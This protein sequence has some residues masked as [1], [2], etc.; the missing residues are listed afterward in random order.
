MG[1]TK[2]KP[3]KKRP[4]FETTSGIIHKKETPASIC[5]NIAGKGTS[6]QQNRWKRETEQTSKREGVLK[7]KENKEK[8]KED[9]K[10]FH[11]F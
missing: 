6:S 7:G 9:E 3:N 11:P 4:G 10:A 5:I 2:I 8:K 1:I